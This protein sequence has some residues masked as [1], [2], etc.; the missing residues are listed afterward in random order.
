[1]SY[2]IELDKDQYNGTSLDETS[3]SVL[4]PTIFDNK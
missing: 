1:M 4:W 2:F 3:L